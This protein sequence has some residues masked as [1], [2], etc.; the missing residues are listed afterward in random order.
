[1]HRSL[2]HGIG[3]RIPASQPSKCVDFLKD[4]SPLAKSDLSQPNAESSLTF[5]ALSARLGIRRVR[6]T[7]PR[8]IRATQVA[9]VTTGLECAPPGCVARV[10]V[11]GA[12][13]HDAGDPG[14]AVP[15]YFRNTVP[16]SRI[17]G[18]TIR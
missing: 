4:F 13:V 16:S 9:A 6:V 3:A 5:L 8:D 18:K 14:H 11:S 10:T 1:M 15:R 2:D 12:P 7:L 17:N